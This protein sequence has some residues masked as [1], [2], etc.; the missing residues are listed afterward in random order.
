MLTAGDFDGGVGLWDTA[1]RQQTATLAQRGTIYTMAFSPDGESLAIGESSGIVILL[2]RNL[3]GFTDGFPS[4]LIC[5]EVR[6]N[7]TRDEQKANVLRAT[8]SKDMP[9]VSVA[10]LF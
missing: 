10:P 9:Y 6:R 1:T 5:D 7:M 4:R 2:S 3:W 8:V